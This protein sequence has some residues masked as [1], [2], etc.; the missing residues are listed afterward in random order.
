M[1][2][3]RIISDVDVESMLADSS[4]SESLEARRY[5]C[6]KTTPPYGHVRCQRTSNA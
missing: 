6:L 2:V 1:G 5:D 3:S 4:Q